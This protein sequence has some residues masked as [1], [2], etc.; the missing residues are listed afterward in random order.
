MVSL[1][2]IRTNV[3]LFGDLKEWRRRPIRWQRV[4]GAC[5]T[6]KHVVACCGQVTCHER[7]PPRYGMARS[8]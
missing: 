4:V 3:R 2:P 8:V 6:Q 5:R 7:I 1:R